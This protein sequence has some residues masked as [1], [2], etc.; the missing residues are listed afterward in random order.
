MNL[1]LIQK[2]VETLAPDEQDR[3][4]AYLTVLRMQRTPEHAEQL[5]RRLDD[6]NPDHWLTLNELKAKLSKDDDPS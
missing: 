6:R 5:S 3:L 4:A 2:E 1:A